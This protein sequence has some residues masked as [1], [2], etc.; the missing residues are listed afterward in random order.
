MVV[1]KKCLTQAQEINI[2]SNSV[3]KK[4]KKVKDARDISLGEYQKIKP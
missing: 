3:A 4:N 2:L 1:K